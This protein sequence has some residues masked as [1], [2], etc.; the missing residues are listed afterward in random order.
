MF[1][2]FI[3]CS[4][5]S[6]A[7]TL[8]NGAVTLTRLS[9]LPMPGD[10]WGTNPVD[11]DYGITDLF[12]NPGFP[13]VEKGYG[14]ISA[15]VLTRTV[16]YVTGNGSA[17]VESAATPLQFGSTPTFGNV[18]IR[19]GPNADVF[20]PPPP[21]IWTAGGGTFSG[22][23]PTGNLLGPPGITA[24]NGFTLTPNQEYYTPYLNT[25]RGAIGGIAVFPSTTVVGSN[26][27]MAVYG[28]ASNGLPGNC[29]FQ[30]NIRPTAGV[31]NLKTDVV[32]GTWGV[33]TGPIRLRPGWFYIGFVSD[34]AIEIGC[35]SRASMMGANPLGQL[36]AFGWGAI[37]ARTPTNSYATGMPTGT[38]GG[39]YANA[40]NQNM[41]VPSFFLQVAN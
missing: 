33:R 32:P 8:G 13:L 9:G 3:E 27:K 2:E 10:F 1:G 36:D 39:T 35:T 24:G 31:S 21:S 29:H 4:T 41:S 15:G 23:A 40:A 11:V 18:R 25:I 34:S 17:F 30:S 7:G 5:T 37:V 26:I 20:I 6:I 22:W 12:T 16:P 28:V 38:P 14:I 19:I